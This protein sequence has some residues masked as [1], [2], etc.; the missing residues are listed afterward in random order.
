MWWKCGGEV[1]ED[2]T[3]SLF[4]VLPEFKEAFMLFD[5]TPK[6]E[7]KISY[8]Q[9]GDVMRALGQNPTN[10]EVMRVL[11][12]PKPEGQKISSS[13]EI[14]LFHLFYYPSVWILI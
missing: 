13:A 14:T 11:G 5:R 6:G 1:S 10:S 7:M 4:S 9:C 3:L 8:A 2:L 12:K